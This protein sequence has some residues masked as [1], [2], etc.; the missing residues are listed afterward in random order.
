MVASKVD[1][2]TDTIKSILQN[3]AIIYSG[4]V[5]SPFVYKP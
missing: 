1:V 3:K 5:G 4:L 2:I